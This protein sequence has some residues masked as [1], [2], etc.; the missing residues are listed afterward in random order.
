[1]RLR[2]FSLVIFA[3]FRLAA[4]TPNA[5]RFAFT[6]EAGNFGPT[7]VAVDSGGNTYVAGSV[8][9]SP[10]PATPGAYQSQNAGSV[11]YGGGIGS[12]PEPIPCRNV[13]VIKLDPSGAVI[14]ATYLG[15][16]A[17][18]DATAMAVDSQGNVYVAGTVVGAQT[19]DSPVFPI[20]SG[21]AFPFSNSQATNGNF[22]FLARLNASG[23]QLD[24]ATVIP[25]VFFPYIA[26]D[27]AGE[28][29][30]TGQWDPGFGDFPATPG[31][32]QTA[33]GNPVAA[34]VV[35]KF[36]ASGSA[37][38]W[39]T[40]LSGT[41]G[42]SFGGGIGVDAA[43]NVITAGTTTASDFP[44]TAGRFAASSSDQNL[45]LAKL[46][47]DGS[48]L[49]YATL[50]G[51]AQGSM[52]M[53]PQGDIYFQC[54]SP[55]FPT[56]GGGFGAPAGRGNYLVHVSGDGASVLS[57][58]YLPFILTGL[59]VDAAGNA[60]VAGSGSVA[61]SAG[62]FQPSPLD[63]QTDQ[64]V[65]AKIGPDGEVAG[66]TYVGA[67]AGGAAIAVGSDGSVAIAGPVAAVDFLG[68]AGETFLVANFFPAITLE[69]AASYVAN[70]AVPGELASIEG[71]GMGPAEGLHSSPVEALGGV[72]VYFDNFAAPLIY[73]QAG[74]INVQ[75][76]WEIAGQA[77][78][79]VRVLYNGVEAG[80][81]TVPVGR[82]QPGVFYIDNSDGS[83]NSPSNPARAGDFVT[84]YGTGGGAM[85]PAA[86]TGTE[87]PL[88]PLYS[89]AQAVSVTIGGE[90]ATVLY[91][92]SAP[93]LESGFFQINVR[94][95]AD[96][97]A[98][99]ANLCVTV[100]GAPG[101]PVALSV[102]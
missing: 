65:V 70:T 98:P 87:W 51:P 94:L 33:P 73:A 21:A 77:S 20:T 47:A 32:Y 28:A 61:T 3:A 88:A 60:Y 97:K 91:S 19:A 34:S 76:P 39:G 82:A 79:Q 14:F 50:L 11:C 37:L 101:A 93:T 96:V 2:S 55:A 13:F 43:G 92:G 83:R 30:F 46:S 102:R 86:A 80:R 45:Y 64:L 26:V 81:A 53:G 78:T 4:A 6:F 52:V 38:L 22:A 62:A 100:G 58:I 69:N 44:A 8:V 99:A 25:G 59:A 17:N 36:N 1:M 56:T 42:Q 27:G 18:V 85:S 68:I 16:S 23:A 66:A 95:P 67:P 29:F 35:G 49:L 72:Q 84:V 15:G 40:Y 74:V 10:F 12:V 7:S 24:Y 48:N 5:P 9:G 41:L 89:L 54:W 63:S 57:S 75:A 31:A 71:Y 90:A